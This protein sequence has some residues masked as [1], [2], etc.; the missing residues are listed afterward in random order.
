MAT[1][2]Y[3][4]SRSI[5]AATLMMLASC[6]EESPFT[7]VTRTMDQM[8]SAESE[9]GTM[10]ISSPVLALPNSNFAF[11][12]TADAD[13]FFKDAQSSRQGSVAE[14]QQSALSVGV[15]VNA[16]F[17]PAAGAAYV[18]QLQQYQEA[19]ANNHSAEA[20]TNLKNGL[21]N[22]AAW[23]QYQSD[24]QAANALSNPAAKD[25]AIATAQSKL[26]STLVGA[27][28]TTL[29]A[30]PSAA[31][32]PAAPTNL[33]SRPT[34]LLQQFASGGNFAGFQGLSAN[35]AKLGVTDRT[36]LLTA[37]GDNATKA[38]FQLFG[39]PGLGAEFRD[40][41]VLFGAV[42]V[43]VQPGWRTQ[44][45]F[46]ADITMNVSYKWESARP[47][48]LD[49][50]INDP[51]VPKR[52][53]DRLRKQRDSVVV[54][55]SLQ[56]PPLA[57]I[58]DFQVPL[59]DEIGA[60][61]LGIAPHVAVVSP[62]T[63]TQTLDL[64]A[65]DRK[66][67]DVALS[68]AIAAQL[69]TAGATGQAQAFLKYAQSLQQD[70]ATISPD[71]VVN[72][73]SVGSV[74][75]FQVG[76]RLRAVGAAAAGK[77]SGPAQVLDRQSFPALV[78]IGIEQA[79]FFPQ[80]RWNDETGSYELYEPTLSFNSVNRWVPA[81]KR[82]GFE[83]IK[84]LEHL[85]S[86]F[87]DR[88]AL[89]SETEALSLSKQINEQF[90]NLKA[91]Q[92]KRSKGSG[93]QG[94]SANDEQRSTKDSALG[95]PPGTFG[96][97]KLRIEG[98]KTQ[99]FGGQSTVY[100]PGAMLR[101]GSTA[102]AAS[103]EP[104]TVQAG[105]KVRVAIT[106]S[107]LGDVD[108][109]KIDAVVGDIYPA[110]GGNGKRYSAVLQNG[111]LFIEFTPTSIPTRPS[112]TQVLANFEQAK[113]IFDQ[114]V[115]YKGDLAKQIADQ[116][117]ALDKALEKDIPTAIEGARKALDA[118]LPKV[119]DLLVAASTAAAF[120]ETWSE[121]Q[122]Q[123]WTKARSNQLNKAL[124]AISGGDLKTL[125]DKVKALAPPAT[126][127]GVLPAN[128][129]KDV[130]SEAA[131]LFSG[132]ESARKAQLKATS[133][134]AAS[135]QKPADELN[136]TLA[137]LDAA[138]AQLFIAWDDLQKQPAW[139][140]AHSD[141]LESSAA[142][143]KAAA[144][145]TIGAKLQQ[146]VQDILDRK[147][148]VKKNAKIGS[149]L[150]S[151][152]LLSSAIKKLSTDLASLNQ[153]ISA[154][155]TVL[156]ALSTTLKASGESWPTQGEIGGIQT[157]L[158]R[159][160]AA[161]R[162]ADGNTTAQR[163]SAQSAS[164][165]ANANLKVASDIY[166]HLAGNVTKNAGATGPGAPRGPAGKTASASFLAQAEANVLAAQ[167]NLTQSQTEVDQTI[168]FA[169][170]SRSDPQAV[171]YTPPIAV[172]GG[173]PSDLVVA[174]RTVYLQSAPKGAAAGGASAAGAPPSDPSAV[175]ATPPAPQAVTV[176][177]AGN[178][179]NKVDL[180]NIATVPPSKQPLTARI[181]GNTIAVDITVT[182]ADA[183][184]YFDLPVLGANRHVA[185]PPITVK[186]PPPDTS[187]ATKA[188]S[189]VPTV[190]AV[191]P[192]SLALSVDAGGKA[193][194]AFGVPFFIL[195]TNLDQVDLTALTVVSGQALID[196]SAANQPTLTGGAIKV[197]LV[198]K[199]ASASV[200]I[201]LPVKGAKN[202]VVNCLPLG[203]TLQSK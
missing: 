69:A 22:S 85:D 73:Y 154:A 124:A 30:F 61:L 184:I 53:R 203:V 103:V 31:T 160:A 159:A 152:P 187:S 20:L 185:T 59:D 171:L 29:P 96:L 27:K 78:I 19:V 177:I 68:L 24:V 106:G 102:V 75:G 129:V 163:I 90:G 127:P 125:K 43:S 51:R 25:S 164:N 95:I 141:W 2:R 93:S 195:G 76:P 112:G 40:K 134:P 118:E 63:D 98:L 167:A 144:P 193:I 120:D 139:T 115:Q 6:A 198:I 140:T 47:S 45:G 165:L 169:L 94:K 172:R 142:S 168:I 83:N 166:R 48:V 81:R 114:I 162:Q 15:G 149:P 101:M 202:Q 18:A 189:A 65:S 196:M 110:A 97:L 72:A 44:K 23:T 194:P 28:P 42:T 14:F 82:D 5:L 178:N 10:G 39:N 170:H 57:N 46:A 66:E 157:N 128:Q 54:V 119:C 201:G 84:G 77:F 60:P 33:V 1:N 133:G 186:A 145:N 4:A 36:A 123:P 11:N 87:R 49:Q 147:D 108:L 109:E 181:V 121:L 190:S 183:A 16:T 21:Q 197:T 151:D 12:L 50:Y 17:N 156:D 99:L 55:K 158:I 64:Q 34:D 113:A 89:P 58:D 155:R 138:L 41:K 131:S 91:Q 136:A 9:Y 71:V 37:G 100:L 79:G 38:I 146:D 182:S 122:A 107:D 153:A 175:A 200:V 111:V 117:T 104:S 3:S 174:P 70:F 67:R 86:I 80:V 180:A 92:E 130:T 126:P 192:S 179:L 88:E 199:D 52:L 13:Q 8:A 105:S 7:K 116:Q 191:S 135:L 26:A 74:F 188:S 150:P 137:Q 161:L 148:W 132:L 143:L 176:L 173:D 62:L 56:L 32:Q 35:P